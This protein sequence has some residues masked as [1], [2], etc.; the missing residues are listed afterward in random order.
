MK[1]KEQAS[2]MGKNILRGIF[3]GLYIN[4]L[5]LFIPDQVQL[6][7][8]WVESK[9]EVSPMSLIERYYHTTHNLPMRP[10]QTF[11]EPSWLRNENHQLTQTLLKEVADY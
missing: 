4:I 11:P 5:G 10:Y 1:M 6:L 7:V 8:E 9:I 2:L 3:L